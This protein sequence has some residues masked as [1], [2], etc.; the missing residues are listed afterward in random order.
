VIEAATAFTA[1]EVTFVIIGEGDQK[2][3]VVELAKE[4]GVYGT[5]VR[6][7]PFQP[8]EVVPKSVTAGDVH[9]ITVREGFAGVN[10]SI[11]LYTAMAAGKPVLAI[12]DPRDDEAR[13]VETHEIGAHVPQGDV[14]E[15][16]RAINR[17]R[18]SSTLVAQQGRTARRTYDAYYTK[19]A[20]IEKY[21]RLFT[22]GAE[23]VE[24]SFP[25][26]RRPADQ[27]IGER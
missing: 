14:A 4:R 6:F 3:Q 5:T 20:A 22:Q 2:E 23:A 16:I 26:D 10:L 11:K 24:D 27:V 17:W 15:V 18:T 21:K 1:D 8:R 12:A 13:L 25:F 9:L 7:L 19:D